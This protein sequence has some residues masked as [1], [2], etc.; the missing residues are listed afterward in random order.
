[1]DSE[2]PNGNIFGH[3][4][5]RGTRNIFML[6]HFRYIGIARKASLT[7]FGLV[8]RILMVKLSWFEML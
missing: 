6:V 8:S 7:F 1:M 4:N 2:E 5:V 3:F